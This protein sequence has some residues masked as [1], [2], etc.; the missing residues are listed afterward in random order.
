M[1][2]MLDEYNAMSEEKHMEICHKADEL[3]KKN[4]GRM[5]KLTLKQMCKL[6]D[7]L[8]HR[9]EDYEED[10]S[11]IVNNTLKILG[12]CNEF[13]YNYENNAVICDGGIVQQESE[14][15]K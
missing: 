11:E 13:H 1:T 8:L 3:Q 14:Q 15:Q 12:Y 4:L 5:K 2:S 7:F 6:V 10:Y 9:Y